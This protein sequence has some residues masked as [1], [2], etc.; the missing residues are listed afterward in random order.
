MSITV[1]GVRTRVR[2]ITRRDNTTELSND[3]LDVLILEACREISKRTFCLKSS[4]T[5]TL[6]GDGTTISKPSDMVDSESAIDAFYLDSNLEDP[7]SF[8]EWRAGYVAGYAYRDQT[9]HVNPSSSNTRSYTLYYRAMHAA[10]S[11]N[12]EFEDDLK[13]AVVWLTSKRVYENYELNEQAVKAEREYERELLVNA[14]VEP[15]IS[16]MRKTRE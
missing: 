7:I 5:G 4:T 13:M 9:I 10:L 6:A 16:R 12:L 14:P 2:Q 3:D 11:T 1:S 15:T 8:D